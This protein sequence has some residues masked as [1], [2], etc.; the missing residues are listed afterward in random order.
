[1]PN[2]DSVIFKLKMLTNQCAKGDALTEVK[3]AV[4]LAHE[5]IDDVLFAGKIFQ[6]ESKVIS[7]LVDANDGLKKIG[8]ALGKVK[9]FCLDVNTLLQIRDAVAILSDDKVVYNDKMK[10][11]AAF[12]MLFQ[13]FGRFIRLLPPPANQWQRFFESF[14]LFSSMAPKL[15]PNMRWAEWWAQIDSMNGSL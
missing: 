2:L 10:A 4:D 12:D 1:M 15:D 6:G 3:D 8:S 5:R 7:K 11:A 13:G 9:N 14:T